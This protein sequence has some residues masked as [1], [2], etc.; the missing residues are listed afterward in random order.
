M[1]VETIDLG[2]ELHGFLAY[3]VKC[4]TMGIPYTIYGY[5]GKQVR[6]NIHSADLARA[7]QHF[8]A[9]PRPG[10]V[11]N[12]GGGW[13]SNC[14]ILEAI[15]IAEELTGKKLDYTI[16]DKPREADHK[17][18]ISDISKFKAHYPDWEIE[19]NIR[20]IIKDLIDG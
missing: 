1:K 15:D 16:V 12:I 14:S 4:I 3:L 20:E 13:E 17:W 9:N 11:Y 2:I 7:F 5:K 10:E 19:Y 8:Y 18:W 6:D